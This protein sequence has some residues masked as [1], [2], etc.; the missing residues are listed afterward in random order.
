MHVM[1]HMWELEEYKT[2]VVVFHLFETESCFVVWYVLQS[3]RPMRFQN[4]SRLHLSSHHWT[5]EI[6]DAFYSV[7][8]CSHYSYFKGLLNYNHFSFQLRNWRLLHGISLSVVNQYD[9]HIYK[10]ENILLYFLHTHTHTKILYLRERT[11]CKESTGQDR[12]RKEKENYIIIF[13]FKN[14][15]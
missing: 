4:F 1:M 12:M 9:H 13:N 8:F 6:I 3:L 11:R 14:K 10:H 15:I 2:L 7:S 5:A